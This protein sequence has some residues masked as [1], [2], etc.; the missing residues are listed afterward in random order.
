MTISFPIWLIAI[1]YILAILMIILLLKFTLNLFI[2]E[3]SNLI[4]FRFINKITYPVFSL[5]DRVTPNFMVQPIIPL[6]LAWIVL[7]VRLYGLP[8]FLGNKYMGKFAFVFEKDLI[9]QFKS[10]IL[11]VALNL[12]YG[13]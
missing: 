4:F 1:D 9:A 2:N 8:L 11:G 5:T 6:Y 3:E 7:M 12:N 10:L 13:I